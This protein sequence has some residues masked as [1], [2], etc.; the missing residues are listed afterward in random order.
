M[1]F[2]YQGCEMRVWTLF[3]R[4]SVFDL[5]YDSR[6]YSHDTS[7]ISA[8]EIKPGAFNRTDT[9]ILPKSLAPYSLFEFRK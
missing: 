9:S 7:Q 6:L 4:S 2:Y 5:S 1:G 8:L 3:H